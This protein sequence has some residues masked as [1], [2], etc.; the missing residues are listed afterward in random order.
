MMGQTGVATSPPVSYTNGRVRGALGRDCPASFDRLGTSSERKVT[1]Y[2]HACACIHS[3]GA[4]AH[5]VEMGMSLRGAATR[6][7]GCG[8]CQVPVLVVDPLQKESPIHAAAVYTL[9][10]CAM[11][12][13]RAYMVHEVVFFFQGLG[14]YCAGCVSTLLIINSYH[15]R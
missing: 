2:I 5:I 7:K 3:M 4:C 13:V 1:Y 6:A 9:T 11:C 10:A 15:R 12:A 14:R 8:T